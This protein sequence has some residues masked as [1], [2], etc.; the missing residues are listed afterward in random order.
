M[1]TKSVIVRIHPAARARLAGIGLASISQAV[2]ALIAH[3]DRSGFDWD[4]VKGL[5]P[6]RMDYMGSAAYDPLS[7]DTDTV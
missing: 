3:A 2:D 1:A 4:V 6:V 5:M 7:D